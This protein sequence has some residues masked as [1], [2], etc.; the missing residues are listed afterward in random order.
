[1]AFYDTPNGKAALSVVAAALVGYVA[2]TGEAINSL[3][4]PGLQPRVERAGTLRDTI[5]LLQAQTDSAKKDLATTSIEDLKARVQGYRITLGILREF[6]PQGSEVP[7]LLDDISTRAKIRG[8]NLS[9]VVPRPVQPGP[10]PFDTYAYDM[11]VIGRYQQVGEFLADIAS[12]RR[13]IVPETV[14]LKAA[15]ANQAKALGDTSKAMLQATFQVRTY[16]KPASGGESG[17]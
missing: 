4:L 7:N 17:S 1:M 15:D 14:T 10:A 9:Q 3:G 13:I 8:V 2:Y 16:V 6:V 5:A 12:L 11:A